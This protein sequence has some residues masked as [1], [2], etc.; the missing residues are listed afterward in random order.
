MFSWRKCFHGECFHGEIKKY[1]YFSVEK[2][3]LAGAMF[4]SIQGTL[5]M[6]PHTKM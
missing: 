1:Q 4:L 5:K 3:M 6:C 2:S